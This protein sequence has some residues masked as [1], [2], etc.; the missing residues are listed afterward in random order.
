[1]PEKHP[2]LLFVMAD[3]MGA[4]AMHCAGNDEIY[5]PNLDRLAKMGTRLENLFCVSPVCS[6][7]RLS[8]YTGQIPSQHGVH[9][10]LAK[11][12]FD[13]KNVLSDELKENFA[14]GDDMPY[15]YRW[16]SVSL[17][18]D[19]AIHYLRGNDTFTDKLAQAGY[20]CGLSGKW[21]MG[22]SAKPQ[23]G[24]TYWKTTGNGGENYMYP[25]VWE[26]GKM[27]MKHNCYVTDYITDNAVRFLEQRDQSRPFCLAVHYTAPHSP[28]SDKCHPWKY[29][30]RYRDCPFNSIPTRPI[31]HWVPGWDTPFEEWKKKP[32]PGVRFIH[33]NYAPVEEVWDEYVLES[34]KGYYAA[35]T[36]MDA[37][38]GRILDKLERDGLLE[39]TLIVFTGDNGSNMGH[40]GIVGKGNGTYP[41]NMYDTSVK[42]PGIFCWP[43]HIPEDYVNENMISHYDFLP[44]LLHLCGVEYEQ[45]GRLPGHDVT[46]LLENR[47]VPD[48]NEVVVFDEYGPVRMIRSH[49]WKLVHRYPDG[50]DELFDLVN[51]PGEETNLI[52]RPE[53]Q[54]LRMTMQQHLE[55]WFDRYVDPALDGSREKVTGK[56]QNTSH[57]F[58]Q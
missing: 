52:D 10:W 16:P 34:Q 14:K 12:H 33:A 29:Y 28:W 13:S 19:S 56:G 25:I 36:G 7:A 27:V 18:D 22:D 47:N 4:W 48:E 43:G 1:M 21:H 51:D 3:D 55:S 39:D 11:G 2:N 38:L 9:D 35:V 6:P 8:V 24:F 45:P 42:V 53:L 41:M 15:E 54:T 58:V 49:G 44:T 26:D 20:E 30:D 37:G 5:T 50:P 32:H 17:A 46:E 40:H 57:D 31:N 23:A